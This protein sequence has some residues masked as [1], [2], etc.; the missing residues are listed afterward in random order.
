MYLKTYL[1]ECAL[2]FD[3]QKLVKLL[4]ETFSA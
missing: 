1:E 4:A 3:K 2:H